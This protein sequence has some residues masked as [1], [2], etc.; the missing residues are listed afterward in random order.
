[1][2]S[3]FHAWPVEIWEGSTLARG[4]LAGIWNPIHIYPSAG[5]PPDGL[6]VTDVPTLPD[7][8]LMVQ[9]LYNAAATAAFDLTG[10]W[11]S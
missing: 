4:L 1:M 5:G 3:G 11:R 8:R 7:R 10:P 6:I 9:E 2:D